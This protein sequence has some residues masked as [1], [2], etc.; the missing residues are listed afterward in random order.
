MEGYRH[1]PSGNRRQCSNYQHTPIATA[2]TSHLIQHSIA[3]FN[4]FHPIQHTIVTANASHPIHN[5]STQ[6]AISLRAQLPTPLSILLKSYRNAAKVA[7]GKSFP[8]HR[9]IRSTATLQPSNDQPIPTLNPKVFHELQN[10]Q[11]FGVVEHVKN[12]RHGAVYEVVDRDGELSALK[13]PQLKRD[14][15][16]ILTGLRYI[17]DKGIVHRDLRPEN[18]LVDSGMVLKISD[19]GSAAMAGHNIA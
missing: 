8:A 4:T 16:K 10:G 7:N 3:S 11:T 18:I 13:V 14:P 9:N 17:H 15:R 19:F 2:N 1:R 5:K 12:G 6:P